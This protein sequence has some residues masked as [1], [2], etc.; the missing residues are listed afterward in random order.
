VK[1]RNVGTG[2][3]EGPAARKSPGQTIHPTKEFT[4]PIP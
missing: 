2:E 3:N 1:E 4:C